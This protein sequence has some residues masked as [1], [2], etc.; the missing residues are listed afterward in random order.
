MN[1]AV[2]FVSRLDKQAD[3][4][5]VG[6]AR[7]TGLVDERDEGPRDAEVVE[8]L[9]RFVGGRPKLPASVRRP[10]GDVVNAEPFAS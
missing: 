10:Q 9:D 6:R 3:D 5:V 7:R 1:N 2:R 8:N 4:I